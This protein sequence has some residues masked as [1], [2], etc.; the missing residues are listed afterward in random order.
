[1]HRGVRGARRPRQGVGWTRVR[2][3]GRAR[4]A[5]SGPLLGRGVGLR[6]GSRAKA[7]G[8]AGAD[9]DSLGVPAEDCERFFAASTIEEA[10]QSKDKK[11]RGWT[12]LRDPRKDPYGVFGQHPCPTPGAYAQ[13]LDVRSVPGEREARG[14]GPCL[15]DSR[16][17]QLVPP[18]WHL[19]PCTW[20]PGTRRTLGA[21][22]PA[23]SSTLHS[24]RQHF[25]AG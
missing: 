16:E 25:R 23:T 24:T 7:R 14:W 3:R 20:H 1:M 4:G 9:E 22:H 15:T 11:S 13:L 5:P 18:A 21:P 19:A 6:K 10:S 17:C 8:G 2:G 12:S